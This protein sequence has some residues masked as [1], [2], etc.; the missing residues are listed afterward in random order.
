MS[1]TKQQKEVKAG[2]AEV[3]FN[4]LEKCVSFEVVKSSFLVLTFSSIKRGYKTKIRVRWQPLGCCWKHFGLR[5]LHLHPQLL[6][7]QIPFSRAE[8]SQGLFSI[9]C[10]QDDIP[11]FLHHWR[12]GL[13]SW[14]HSNI[15]S[16][17]RVAHNLKMASSFEYSEWWTQKVSKPAKATLE[18]R[19]ASW[20]RRKEKVPGDMRKDQHLFLASIIYL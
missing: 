19:R 20:E 18:N 17:L 1:K 9:L 16:A 14:S 12:Q 2:T 8:S 5:A 7:G 6:H 4:S 13:G 11:V 3:S 15:T 10:I